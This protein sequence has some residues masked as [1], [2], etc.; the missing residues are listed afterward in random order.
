MFNKT[1]NLNEEL[2]VLSRPLHLVFPVQTFWLKGIDVKSDRNDFHGKDHLSS[3]N[4][5]PSF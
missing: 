3:T 4:L 1:S 5:Q 2:T